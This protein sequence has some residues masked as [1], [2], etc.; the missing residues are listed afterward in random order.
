[1]RYKYKSAY[2]IKEKVYLNNK[3]VES[4][5]FQYKH[6]R[7]RNITISIATKD[8][9]GQYELVVTYRGITSMNQ[10]RLMVS[11]VGRLRVAGNLGPI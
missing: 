6:K 7:E 11:A 5:S 9:G 10:L 1:M 3:L 4:I 8:S 2:V